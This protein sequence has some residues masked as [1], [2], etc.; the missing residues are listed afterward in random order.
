MKL[1][2]QQKSV[3]E[4]LGEFDVWVTPSLTDL[5]DTRKFKDVLS[6]VV[7]VFDTLGPIVADFK[8]PSVVSTAGI[9]EAYTALVCSRI[10]Q[11][12]ESAS[13]STPEGIA[14]TALQAFAS[15]LF[16]VTGKSDN[17]HKCQFPLYLKN[18]LGWTSLPTRK[19][20]RGK[21][22]I[23][24][25]AIP[26]VLKSDVYM[27]R[28]AALLVEFE[29]GGMT[30]DVNPCR[31]IATQLLN[32]FVEFVLAGDH[33]R[34]QFTVLT[35]SYW[36]LKQS[37]KAASALLAPLVAFQVRGSVSASGGHEPE[38]RLRRYMLDWGLRS[39]VDF[40]RT[41]VV[42]DVEA[43]RLEETDLPPDAADA[44]ESAN[45]DKKTRA[46]DFVLPFRVDGWSP[47]LFVQSQFYAGD[48]GSVSHKNVDQTDTSRLNAEAVMARS[49]SNSP[50]PLFLEYVDGAGYSSALAGDLR[51]I[52]S[53]S[54][55]DDFFQIRSAAIR[56]R[57]K[58]QQIGFL[59]PLEI[60]HAII[61]TQGQ[62]DGVINLLSKEGYTPVEISRAITVSIQTG[63]VKTVDQETIAVNVEGEDTVR[64][65]LLLDLIANSG[66]TFDS[67]VGLQGV[68]LVPG[69]GPYF[70]AELEMLGVLIETD[71][72]GVWRTS[73]FTADLKWLCSVGFVILR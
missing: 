46:F 48:S 62:K 37:G 5:K 30:P 40:N 60:A 16:I 54:T 29:D 20:T 14:L 52:L 32:Q 12:S 1:N 24:E 53:K 47:R 56:L 27:A 28:V 19:K 11:R 10:E 51:K 31:Q 44:E 68:V 41:D 50:G 59:T 7:D 67:A 3:P 63:L 61:R 17:N 34:E 33:A 66:K 49:W 25:Q 71:I 55:T 35:Q 13:K 6:S 69:F 21:V 58:L 15:A 39:D 36:Q 26:R 45:Q 57:R 70:G 65:Y 23:V 8:D 18:Q 38:D 43:G 72:P 22:E 2:E 42:L 9:A 73:T 4:W 64:R